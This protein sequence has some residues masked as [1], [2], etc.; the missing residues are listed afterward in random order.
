[1]SDNKHTK[2]VIII[3]DGYSDYVVLKQFV[4]AIFK[5][6][7]A[8]DSHL[9][10]FEDYKALEPLKIDRFV[11]HFID[12][13]AKKNSYDLFGEQA[14][15]LKKQVVNSLIN[16]LKMLQK[17]NIALDNHD[18]LIISSDSEKPL[19]H[20]NNYFQKWAYSVEAIL[21]VAIDEFYHQLVEQGYS[22]QYLPLIVPLICFPS[23]EILV[24]ACTEDIL[25]FDNQCRS[26]QA[27]PALKQKVWGT[28]SIDE[29]RRNGMLYGVLEA[30]MTPDALD[31]IYKN[32]P[33]A[34]KM[35]KMLNFTSS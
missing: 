34:R 2:Q 33:E 17:K 3:G 22:E 28:D 9:D 5:G 30:Y 29:A 21:E 20:R 4:L 25:D 15:E 11:N 10:F 14:T 6:S 23:I 35:I 32:I 8:N 1:M 12:K 27:K 31:K 18:L 26:L 24:A 19:G 13:A 7:G 16:T